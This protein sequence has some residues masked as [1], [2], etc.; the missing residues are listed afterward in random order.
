M[1]YYRVMVSCYYSRFIGNSKHSIPIL[2][3]RLG[4]AFVFLYAGIMSIAEPSHWVGWVPEWVESFGVSLEAALRFHAV[5]DILLGVLFL[6]G[7]YQKW[8]GI[9][10]GLL[11]IVITIVAG[12]HVLDTTFRD[13]GLAMVSLGYAFYPVKNNEGYHHVPKK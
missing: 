12:T 7:V 11:L 4:L 6:L 13:I 10:T 9:S 5:I 1:L 2:C 3:L 8:V